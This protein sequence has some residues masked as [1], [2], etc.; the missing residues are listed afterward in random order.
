MASR[1]ISTSEIQEGALAFLSKEQKMDADTYFLHKMES[2][3]HDIVT[4]SNKK[5]HDQAMKIMESKD[6]TKIIPALKELLA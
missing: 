3:L 6:P 5:K 2:L 1:T 4:E